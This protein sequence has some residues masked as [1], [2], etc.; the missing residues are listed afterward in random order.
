MV[1]GGVEYSKWAIFLL[2]GPR[3]KVMSPMTEI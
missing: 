2:K 1:K 3:G